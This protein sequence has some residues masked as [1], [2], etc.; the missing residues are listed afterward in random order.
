MAWV[1]V[2][3]PAF[4]V[5][6]IGQVPSLAVLLRTPTSDSH[7]EACVIRSSFSVLML[8]PL[9]LFSEVRL[10]PYWN[11]LLGR[12][13]SLVMPFAI[14][15]PFMFAPL[16]KQLKKQ[17]PSRCCTSCDTHL[18][19]GL[20]SSLTSVLKGFGPRESSAFC[21]RLQHFVANTVILCSSVCTCPLMTR[22]PTNTS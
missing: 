19:A 10:G 8:N 21:R 22:C 18:S 9:H 16:Q 12:H 20:C 7:P 17:M 13:I 4:I 14:L 3:S 1:H 2:V 5:G 15:T 11:F 6:N